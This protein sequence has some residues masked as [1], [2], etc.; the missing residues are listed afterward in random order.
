MLD[1]LR[2][3][4]RNPVTLL[5]A[6]KDIEHSQAAVLAQCLSGS[7]TTVAGTRGT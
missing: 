5:T 2:K 1:R 7:K 6:T 3:L 4:A